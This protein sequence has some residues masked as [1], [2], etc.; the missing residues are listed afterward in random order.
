[1]TL[2]PQ[3]HTESDSIPCDSHILVI[4]IAAIHILAIYVTREGGNSGVLGKIALCRGLL[5][6]SD[7]G[8]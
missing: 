8:K 5:G 6:A 7:M 4:H 2:A 1:M 3:H